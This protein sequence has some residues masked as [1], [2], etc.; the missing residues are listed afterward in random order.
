LL[1]LPLLLLLRLAD[2]LL[3][4]PPPLPPLA[5]FELLRLF[6]CC[7]CCNCWRHLARRFLNHTWKAGREMYS[8][9]VTIFRFKMVFFFG[10]LYRI[11]K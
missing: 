6:D 9:D 5:F 3:Q 2:E 1:L 11:R 7:C 4:L 8:K 10:I